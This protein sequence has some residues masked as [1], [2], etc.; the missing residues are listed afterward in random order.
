[1]NRPSLSIKLLSFCCIAVLT[2]CDTSPRDDRNTYGPN[3]NENIR[4]TGPRTAEEEKAGF[5]LPPGF[6]I[7]LFA[8]EPDIDK[9][10]NLSFDAKGRL[11]VTQSF[12]YPFPS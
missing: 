6:E 3:F 11:W 7:E 2:G 12:E 9:P 8:S 10:M 1:M 5:I 4:P